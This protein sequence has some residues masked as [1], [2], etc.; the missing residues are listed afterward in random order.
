MK[1]RGVREQSIHHSPQF[2]TWQSF[3]IAI[4]HPRVASTINEARQLTNERKL[5]AEDVGVSWGQEGHDP[6]HS[7]TIPNWATVFVTQGQE[8]TGS[9]SP[10]CTL[11]H[12]HT[13]RNTLPVRNREIST[14]PDVISLSATATTGTDVIRFYVIGVY[15]L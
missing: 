12:P 13:S 6:H 15:S 11:T 2:I 9:H 10:T 8:D 5:D 1:R 7:W 3:A 14:P 4:N